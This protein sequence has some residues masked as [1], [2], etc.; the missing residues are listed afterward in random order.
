MEVDWG[1]AFRIGGLGFGLV[2]AVLSLLSLS[3]WL[4]ALILRRFG[5]DGDEAE[6]KNKGE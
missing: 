3:M 2:F 5:A 4:T 6:G 1:Q